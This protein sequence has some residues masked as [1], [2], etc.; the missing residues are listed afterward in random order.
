LHRQRGCS[1]VIAGSGCRAS[2]RSVERLKTLRYYNGGSDGGRKIDG[3]TVVDAGQF[4]LYD[5][6]LDRA[7]KL[8]RNLAA[9]I[10]LI[11]QCDYV[12]CRIRGRP[13]KTRQLLHE[14]VFAAF[15]ANEGVEPALPI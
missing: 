10:S 13:T 7:E 2:A 9:P 4:A 6:R 8:D 15:A 14:I 12:P 11:D 1:D 3:R 5:P